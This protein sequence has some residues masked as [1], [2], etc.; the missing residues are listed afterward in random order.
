M[1]FLIENAKKDDHAKLIARFQVEMAKETE[2]MELNHEKT[3]KGVLHIFDNPQEGEYWVSLHKGEMIG[4]LL[5]LYEWSDWRQGTVLWVHSVFVKK[6][7]RGKGVY[8]KLYLMLQEKVR[9]NP[10][11]LGIRL[12]VDKRNLDAQKAYKALG[13]TDEHYK[14]FEWMA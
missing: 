11:Y 6:E 2:N 3:E 1:D 14:L 8:K 5:T 12:Y 7:F 10:R 13:M 4:C 9:Q